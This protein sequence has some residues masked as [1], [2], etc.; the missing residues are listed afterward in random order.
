MDEDR[1]GI[2]EALMAV[3]LPE[4]VAATD[5]PT[6]E[7]IIFAAAAAVNTERRDTKPNRTIISPAARALYAPIRS[8]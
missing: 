6:L 4:A 5:L 3:N 8:P 7:R 1:L 2:D